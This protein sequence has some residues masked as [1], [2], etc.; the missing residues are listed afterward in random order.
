MQI[1]IDK[2][3]ELHKEVLHSNTLFNI[4][5]AFR[6]FD[7]D[8]KGFI[9]ET[10]LTQKFDDLK[11][12]SNPSVIIQ[13]F[14]KDG[15]GSLNYSEFRQMVT[16]LNRRY[17][18]GED[19][20]PY[21]GRSSKNSSPCSLRGS[22]SMPAVNPAFTKYQHLSWEDDLKEIVFTISNADNLLQSERNNNQIEPEYIFKQ[23]D[24]Y[25]SGYITVR[26]IA[27]WLAQV[28]GF[29]LHET[30]RELLQLRYAS[31]SGYKITFE[32]FADQVA[33]VLKMEEE[34]EEERD[35]DEEEMDPDAVPMDE[36]EEEYNRNNTR[37]G[38][39]RQRELPSGNEEEESDADAQMRGRRYEEDEAPNEDY[40][41]DRQESQPE[42]DE[43]QKQE[44]SE[45]DD[46][47]SDIKYLQQVEDEG[48]QPLGIE[49]E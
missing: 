34:V 48:E 25:G 12:Y 27:D 11:V 15:D 38:E 23:I 36:Y 42:E 2:N 22:S 31:K 40:I 7:Q 16:P 49:N 45:E 24:K 6:M 33:P 17:Q 4:R 18:S 30:E 37:G 47:G 21:G 1:R 19:Y 46:N 44:Y 13:K 3:T 8:N 26:E 39:E 20:S 32:E 5:E 28:C 35:E 41:P 10:D 14:D 43:E 9:T 29:H